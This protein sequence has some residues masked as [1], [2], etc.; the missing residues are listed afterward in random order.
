ML[1]RLGVRVSLLVTA[2]LL[3]A[4]AAFAQDPVY[5]QSGAQYGRGFFAPLTLGED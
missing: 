4:T 1:H 5:D 3:A 2:A